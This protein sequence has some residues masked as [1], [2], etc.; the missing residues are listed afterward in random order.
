[1]HNEKPTYRAESDDNESS[2]SSKAK[3]SFGSGPAFRPVLPIEAR[4]TITVP[5]AP[6]APR[7]VGLEGVLF[8]RQRI[9]QTHLEEKAK[10]EKEAKEEEESDDTDE[11][12][13]EQTESPTPQ[14]SE[15]KSTVR[16]RAPEASLLH[17]AGEQETRQD[18]EPTEAEHT[19]RTPDDLPG[20]SAEAPRVFTYPEMPA[21]PQLAESHLPSLGEVRIPEQYTPNTAE[22]NDTDR[23]PIAGHVPTTSTHHSLVPPRQPI[24]PF[25]QAAAFSPGVHTSP[26][27][28]SESS[29]ADDESTIPMPTPPTNP[30][31]SYN[32]VSTPTNATYYNQLG[33]TPSPTITTGGNT[34]PPMGPPPTNTFGA[35]PNMF[36]PV[37]NPNNYNLYPPSGGNQMTSPNIAPPAPSS[38]VIEQRR[39]GNPWPYVAVLA[40]RFARRRA[41]KKLEGRLGD[42]ID[43]QAKTQESMQAT[44]RSMQRQ[45]E[46]MATF[47]TRQEA[48]ARRN[49][50]AEAWGAAA[51]V[52][53]ASHAGES[54]RASLVSGQ[55]Q[56]E[57]RPMAPIQNTAEQQLLESAEP[58]ELAPH[59]RVEHSSWHNIVVNERGQ[60]VSGA[61]NYGEG[62]KRER[63]QEII[64]D[65]IA[66][67]AVPG[68]AGGSGAAGAGGVNSYGQAGSPYGYGQDGMHQGALP[69]GMTTP[70]LPQ[71]QPTHVDP[72][73]QLPQHTAKRTNTVMPGPVFWVMALLIV[74]AFF[75]A[76]LI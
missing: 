72:Q 31:H 56:A 59:Q 27:G 58:I 53:A 19:E 35:N 71:G 16:T 65:R 68:G 8:D 37:P 62:F 1:M 33:N 47:Q 4:P 75:A 40:E 60:E 36:P 30:V 32:T 18:I 73:H 29:T 61:I 25:E 70:G 5:E 24:T 34:P 57:L 3:S 74:L 6:A 2:S 51:T 66:A 52:T 13:T 17:V 55:Q 44:Q 67:G 26:E 49:R 11:I 22:A 15:T 64:P 20:H 21:T 54:V 45:Q 42:R 63:Q 39:K 38:Q 46:Q 7:R 10:A 76:A 41:D 28:V 50:T 9:I 23:D 69:S 43:G 48:D 14:A 12:S